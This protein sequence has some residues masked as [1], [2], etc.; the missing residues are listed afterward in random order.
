MKKAQAY[1][2]PL[3]V[4]CPYCGEHTELDFDPMDGREETCWSCS[5]EF[6]VF[7]PDY[8]PAHDEYEEDEEDEEDV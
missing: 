3:M 8:A 7:G 5:K 4:E 2:G 1:E 6:I